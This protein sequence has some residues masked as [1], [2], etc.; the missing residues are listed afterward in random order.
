MESMSSFVRRLLRS[1]R[2]ATAI[3]YGLIVSLIVIAMLAALSQMAQTTVGVWDNVSD[4]VSNA[5]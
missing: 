5:R 4:K 3:E 1:T 2:A